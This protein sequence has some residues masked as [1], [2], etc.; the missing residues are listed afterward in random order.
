MGYGPYTIQEWRGGTDIRLVRNPNY[1]R[2]DEGL[3]RFDSLIF[4]FVGQDSNTNVGRILSGECD[5]LDQTTQ[6]GDLTE[7]LIDLGSSGQLKPAF[8]GDTVFEHADFGIAHISY[9]DGWAPGDRPDFFSDVRIRRALAHCLDRQAVVDTVLF[10]ESVVLD[11]YI[12][13]QHPLF[14]GNLPLYGFD[15]AAGS[16]LLEEAGWVMG[17]DGVR[18]YQGED[19]RIPRGTRL[20][21]NYSTTSASQRQQAAQTLAQSLRSCGIEVNLEFWDPGEYYAEGPEGPLFGRSFDIGQFAWRTGMEPPC[22]LYLSEAIPGMDV[23]RFPYAWG[24][25]NNTGYSNPE[26]DLAC[27]AALGSLPG[28]E[29]YKE[30]HLK[31]QEIFASDLPV[32]PLYLHLKVAAS[33]PDMCHFI[34]D[35]TARSGMWNIEEFDYGD[36]S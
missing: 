28:Q 32:V 21:I 19:Q 17:N 20:S 29:S 7:R 26:F 8:V 10:G 3:P 14:N 12:P 1:F 33:R 25:W 16:A 27:K 34:L 15:V 30:H 23:E 18:V 5:V 2:A 9:D 36:C 13:P 31:A 6:L 35:P 4:R 24:G 11:T 22:D